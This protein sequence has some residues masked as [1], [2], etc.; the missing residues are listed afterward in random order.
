MSISVS[1]FDVCRQIVDTEYSIVGGEQDNREIL[2]ICTVQDTLYGS[3]LSKRFLSRV[4]ID[5]SLVKRVRTVFVTYHIGQ[6]GHDLNC[7]LMLAGEIRAINSWKWQPALRAISVNEPLKILRHCHVVSMS[8]KIMLK[9]MRFKR[10]IF[11]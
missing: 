7:I 4:R 11:I 1:A 8:E 10:R 9:I 3:S 5:A 2:K 6:R